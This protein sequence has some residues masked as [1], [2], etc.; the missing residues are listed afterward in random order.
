[1]IQVWRLVKKRRAA[2]AFNGEG[3]K[4]YGG[5][6][7][8]PGTA[9]VYLADSLALAALEIFVHTGAAHRGMHFVAIAVDLPDGVRIDELEASLPTD[10]R[11]EP[12]P[13]STKG[14]GT[15]WL[16]SLSAPL[17]RVPSAIVPVEHNLVLN[18]LHPDAQRLAIQAPV[19][20]SFDSRMW[21]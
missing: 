17:L 1:M 6:W 21:K 19:P 5:R 4:A 2:E 11:D 16:K 20:F 7:N 14:L 9:A 13:G 10:W 18:P 3:A 8:H 12:P 15:T